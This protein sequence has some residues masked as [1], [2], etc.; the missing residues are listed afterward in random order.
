MNNVGLSHVDIRMDH[1]MLVDKE[2][3]PFKVALVDFGLASELSSSGCSLC[4]TG[5]STGL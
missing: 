1:I 4:V 2:K 5:N 3:Q